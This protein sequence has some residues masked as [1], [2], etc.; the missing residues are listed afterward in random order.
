MK[1]A[2][3]WVL[4]CISVSLTSAR[5]E[6]CLSQ[7]ADTSEL[8]RLLAPFSAAQLQ[9]LV[10]EF[11]Y[12]RRFSS[13]AQ[14][15]RSGFAVGDRVY[16]ESLAYGVTFGKDS[17]V[18]WRR[19][20]AEG[21][22]ALYAHKVAPL[23][24][25]RAPDV[26]MVQVALDSCLR[27]P[28]WSRLTGSDNCR[29]SFSAGLR[30]TNKDAQILP[31]R[32][33]VV[34]GRC[35]R[36]PA[37]PLHTAGETIQCERS[38]DGSVT[39]ELETQAGISLREVVPALQVAK[40]PEEPVQDVQRVVQTEVLGLY[41]SRDYRLMELGRGC[42]TCRLYVAEFAPSAPGATIVWV[43]VVSNSGGPDWLRC[44]A[45]LRC[46]VPEFSTR[47]QRLVSGC[48][49]SSACRIWRL[50]EEGERG[51]DV[52]QMTFEAPKAVCRNCPQGMSYEQ[53][54]E[55]WQAAVAEINARACRE[56]A[57][58]PAQDLR[59]QRGRENR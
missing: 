44:P 13:H 46:G 18:K 5:A 24:K 33:S 27:T 4:V 52:V 58:P 50:S 28:A 48:T 22:R 49:G 1:A 15:L 55:R 41:R 37:G 16:G 2:L 54:H 10:D 9:L 38:G 7:S 14:A 32:L 11:A 3:V 42:M 56:F 40:L 47:E 17:A 34:G 8:H 57:D 36:W 53:A 19:S 20:Y 6:S 45:G 59:R 26:A 25:G 12:M 30:E 23:L 35:A 43:D 51:Q 31:T 39:V 29:F 21:R